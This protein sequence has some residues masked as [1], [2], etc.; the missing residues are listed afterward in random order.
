MVKT[1]VKELSGFKKLLVE[2]CHFK[3]QKFRKDQVDS[4]LRV[5]VQL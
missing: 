3:T 2:I 5:T 4:Y 1:R